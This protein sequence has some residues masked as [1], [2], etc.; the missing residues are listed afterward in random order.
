MV[1]G[2]SRRWRDDMR[3]YCNKGIEVNLNPVVDDVKE[4]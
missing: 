2:V 3:L 4:F 1:R